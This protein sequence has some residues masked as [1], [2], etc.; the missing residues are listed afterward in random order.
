METVRAM[1]TIYPIHTTLPTYLSIYHLDTES[2]TYTPCPPKTATQKVPSTAK[3]SNPPPS[4]PPKVSKLIR[5]RPSKTPKQTFPLAHPPPKFT[6][7]LRFLPRLLLQI[8]Q[9]SSTSH[10]VLPI[11][12]IY[13]PPIQGKSLPKCPRKLHARDIYILQSDA[14]TNLPASTP[15]RPSTSPGAGNGNAISKSE[16]LQYPTTAGVIYLSPSSSKRQQ[17]QQGETNNNTT[18]GEVTDEI[19]FPST[20]QSWTVTRSHKGYKFTSVGAGAGAKDGGGGITLEWRRRFPGGRR[21]VSA[22]VSSASGVTDSDANA[23]ANTNNANNGKACEDENPRFVL[24][25]T[26]GG[27]DPRVRRSGLAGLEKKGLRVGGW[28]AKQLY[29]LSEI[30]AMTTEPI[31]YLYPGS[32]D[33]ENLQ[34]TE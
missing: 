7:R 17:N 11:L 3:Q 16:I 34:C 23:N 22:S 4:A 9:L 20:Q 24:C 2:S 18:T 19:F 1:E 14:Y 29:E 10:R 12:D 31:Q 8:Q 28:E 15:T 25:V 27:A 33:P 26:S 13:Q 6:P 30:Y 21:P 5:I 32:Y